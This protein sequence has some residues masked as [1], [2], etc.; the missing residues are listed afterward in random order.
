MRSDLPSPEFLVLGSRTLTPEFDFLLARSDESRVDTI[1]S[2][3]VATR[4]KCLQEQCSDDF[5]IEQ[6]LSALLGRFS[7]IVVP[8]CRHTCRV[9]LHIQDLRDTCELLLPGQVALKKS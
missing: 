5:Q 1:T 3:S 7:A 4:R 2:M 8:S 9:H 6:P